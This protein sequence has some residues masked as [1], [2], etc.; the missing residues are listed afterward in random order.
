MIVTIDGPSGVGKGAATTA[1]AKRLRFEYLDTGA[2]YRAVAL[3]MIR[4]D[5]PLEDHTRIVAV[6]PELHIAV[7]S[8]YVLLNGNDE[9]AAIRSPE[10]SQGASKVA[11][12][13]AVR[14]F[15]AMEQRRT[16]AGRD[17]VCEGRDQGT[18]VFPGA[19]CKFY[20][21][22]DP[23][24]RAERR[25]AELVAKGRQVTVAEVLADQTTRDARD[26]ERDFAPMRP[27]HDAVVLNTTHLGIEQVADKL[28]AVVRARRCCRS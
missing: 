25:A 24:V 7:L 21:D 28:E 18:F 26:A 20:I 19:E 15:L 6:L 8:G 17:I 10:V 3:A 9:S 23:T 11:V 22:A 16:A 5:I 12:I 13:P 27:A 4:R 1:L 14:M 2:M